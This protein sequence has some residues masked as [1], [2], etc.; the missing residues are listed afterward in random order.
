MISSAAVGTDWKIEA[1]GDIDRDGTVDLVMRRQ[2]DGLIIYWL[3]NQDGTKKSGGVVSSA[4]V[5]TDWKIEASGDIDRDGTVDLVMRRQS[6]GL[7][8]YWLL[9]QNGTKKSGGVISSAAV[10][11]DWEIEASGDIDR[12][13]TVDLVMRR[14]SD[15]LI[16]YWLLNQN[17]TKKSGGV[18]L[19]FTRR[20][21]LDD[22]RER[23]Y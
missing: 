12:D 21:Q 7:I 17:G 11:T 6:D 19:V 18:V 22:S 3:L 10:G 5:G 20:Q 2:S 23:R 1:S 13:G 9:N 15:G 4:A 8:I 14:Q 16:I